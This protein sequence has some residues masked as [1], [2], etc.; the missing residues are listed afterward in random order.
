MKHSKKCFENIIYKMG[1][2]LHHLNV[3][4]TCR[5]LHV[6]IVVEIVGMSD[7]SGLSGF[8]ESVGFVLTIVALA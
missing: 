2:I 7:I 6:F 1:I 5:E 8:N 4:P 3:L